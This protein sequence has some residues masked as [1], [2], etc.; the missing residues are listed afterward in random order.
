MAKSL[1]CSSK[2]PSCGPEVQIISETVHPSPWA[3]L[4]GVARP[5]LP[6]TARRA[7]ALSNSTAIFTKK[8]P[9]DRLYTCH[10]CLSRN[11][12]GTRF[13][14][15]R[16]SEAHIYGSTHLMIREIER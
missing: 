5:G 14:E 1:C 13:P 12:N 15:I 6:S 8:S 2:E 7:S 11:G 16:G 4:R 10:C 9:L 3:S